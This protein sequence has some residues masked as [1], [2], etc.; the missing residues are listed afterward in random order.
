MPDDPRG[1]RIER[2]SSLHRSLVRFVLLSLTA[3][4][5]VTGAVTWAG[6]RFA[7]DEAIHDAAGQGERMSRL[8]ASPLVTEET[9]TGAP[10]EGA[11]AIAL[12]NRASDASVSHIL[13]WDPSGRVIWADDSSLIGRVYD[14]PPEIEELFDTRRVLTESTGGE[15]EPGHDN[16]LPGRE[17]DEEVIEVYVGARGADGQPFVF[18]AYLPSER[19]GFEPSS[20]LWQVL[21]ISLGG[22]VLF[23]LLILPLAF[24]LARRVDRGRQ[25]RSDMIARSLSSWHAERRRLAQDLHDGVIQDLSAAGYTVP[26]VTAALPAG[27]VGDEARARAEQLGTALTESLDSLRSLALDLF[28]ADLG[29]AGLVL[30]LR[31]LVARASEGGLSTRLDVD[32]DLE[33]SPAAAG[34]VYRVA[35]EALRN[36][37][38]HA[39][40]RRVSVRVVREGTMIL[41]EVDDDGVGL[42]HRPANSDPG[43]GRRH[44]GLPLL[45]ALLR[46]VDGTL[47][48]SRRHGGGTVLQ[49]RMPADLPG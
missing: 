37:E 1:G 2:S 48:V 15:S 25:Q 38:Q 49:A 24:T 42:R 45:R 35:R 3:L 23:Q 9:R 31:D 47:A 21:P 39:R 34:V 41:T 26:A 22:L 13:L 12:R 19:V 18:E 30:A 33:L 6:T 46:D 17:A 36:V 28:P 44:F 4:A 8:L 5:A 43:R 14:L 7:E 27:P 29:G 16:G 10:P 32:D 20:L 11:L 40:A